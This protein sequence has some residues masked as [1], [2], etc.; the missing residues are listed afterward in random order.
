MALPG[1]LIEYLISG[2]LAL[3]WLAPILKKSGI[4]DVQPALL[5]LMA[6]ALYVVGMVVDFIA[7]LLVTPLK[8][9]VR[10]RAIRKHHGPRMWEDAGSIARQVKLLMHAPDVA[11]E[12]AMRSSRDRIARGAAVNAIVAVVLEHVFHLYA[13]T[14]SV[15]LWIPLILV[16]VAMW[17]VFEGMSFG[18]ELR[19]ELEVNEKLERTK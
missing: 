8:P 10:R 11:K 12:L 19:A 9:L 6:I 1:L 3:V 15:L 13:P 5:P 14:M 4:D 2:A 17:C 7:Y 18:Y 16:L